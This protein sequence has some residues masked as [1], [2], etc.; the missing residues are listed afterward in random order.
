MGI[1]EAAVGLTVAAVA[2]RMGV[3][4]ATLRTW[5]RRYGIGPGAHVAGTHRRDSAEDL[6]RLEH[7]R[8]LVIAGVPP[9]EAARAARSAEPVPVPWQPAR[10]GGGRVLAQPGAGQAERGLARAAQALDIASCQGIVAG[11]LRAH[12][13]VWTWDRL[14][15]PVLTAIGDRWHDTGRGIEIEH[16]LSTA[17]H[18]ALAAVTGALT[19]PVNAR[20]VVLAA[21]P[22]EAHTLPLW[23][24]AAG[25]AERRVGARVLGPG[26]PVESLAHAVRVL[27]PSAVFVW[28][29]VPGSAEAD[30]LGGLPA[31][32]PAPLVIVGG[33]GWTGSL[34]G[35][36]G[37]SD[38]LADA[39]ARIARAAGE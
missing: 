26:L 27:G 18:A 17:I 13:V 8:R 20:A 10:A 12:G 35:H 1:D 23:A 39:V 25:L 16:S 9:A 2:R 4:P 15:V 30:M 32:R 29:Q 3:A 7:M 38:G 21:A 19:Q 33:P 31:L 6:A 14:L 37:R 34:P 36:A 28:S 5:D 22:G 24:V 11:S